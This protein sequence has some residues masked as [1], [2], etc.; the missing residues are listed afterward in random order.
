MSNT[1]LNVSSVDVVNIST[2]IVGDT[3]AM[4]PQMEVHTI[5]RRR[6]A[7]CSRLR[8]CRDSLIP[9]DLAD[10]RQ[11]IAERID[12]N[13]RRTQDATRASYRRCYHRAVAKISV[14]LDDDLYARVRVAAGPA[15]VSRWL[16]GAAATR[17]RSEALLTA[18]D[19]IAG[20]TGGPYTDH[21]LAEA[22]RWLPSSSTPAR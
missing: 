18:A 1:A 19:A 3:I 2:P 13:H 15:G 11:A 16:A 20:A 7:A 22:R 12:T 14:S 4:T 8:L 17:L 6:N 10:S 5:A 9:C 21:E